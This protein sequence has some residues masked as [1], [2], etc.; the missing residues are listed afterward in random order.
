LKVEYRNRNVADVL[1]MT[2]REAFTFFR[3][4]AH[5]QAKLKQLIDVG[6]EYLRLGQPANTLSA[7]ESQRLKLA[8]Y[9][10]ALKR[11][12][13]LFLLDEP[14]TGLHFS[15]VKQ[16]LECFGALLDVGHSLIVAE[17]HPMVLQ[18]ADY[19]IELGPGAADKGGQVVAAGTPEEL[20]QFPYSVTAKV[21]YPRTPHGR[22]P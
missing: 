21:L 16:L 6:L 14:T 4:A 7:G 20:L 18:A 3:G 13:T 11:S 15:D 22:N 10:A 1:D 19:I 2:A 5:I 12:R 9:I 17:H 8:G